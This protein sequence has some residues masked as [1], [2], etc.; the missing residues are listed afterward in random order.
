MNRNAERHY[1][2][3]RSNSSQHFF[4]GFGKPSVI[5]VTDVDACSVG[6]GVAERTGNDSQI[7]N[8]IIVCKRL[9]SS[10]VATRF[11]VLA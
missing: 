11:T 8:R 6:V 4:I 5:D 9:M 3:L 2:F 7:Y 10:S 1:V